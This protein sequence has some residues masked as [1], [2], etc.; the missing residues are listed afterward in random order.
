MLLKKFGSRNVRFAVH[1]LLAAIF[2]SGLC[3]VP[4]LTILADAKSYQSRLNEIRSNKKRVEA[5]IR[6]LRG[7]KGELAFE[8]KTLDKELLVA[9]EELEGVKKSLETEKEE[10]ERLAREL[11][12][13]TEDLEKKRGQLAERSVEIYKQGDLSY[14]DLVFGAEDFSDFIDRVF[15]LQIIYENDQRLITS[16]KD[17]IAEVN[18]KKVEVNQKIIVIEEM[19]EEVELRIEEINVHLEAKKNAMK[20]I[21][22]DEAL[23]NKQV[24]EIEA[25]SKR[26]Q[27]ELRRLAQS[28]S[29]YKG[30]PWT[31]N[32]LKPLNGPIT[33]GF[34][35]RKHPI[36]KV[37]KMHAGVDIDGVTG[38]P[39]KAGG[40][41]KVIYADWRGGYGKCV[42]IDHGKGIVTLYA[43][44]SK[45]LVKKGQIVSAGTKIGKVGSTGYSTGSH[46]HF[47]V[48]VNGK[49]VNPL[50]RL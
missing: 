36:F 29:G 24:K 43:H 48:R 42:M 2:L 45:I 28:G 46:L 41:G 23:Y 44:L 8:L 32:F 26:I 17:Q 34:G 49:P 50:T 21:R 11:E 38:D 37:K 39:I 35:W 1:V 4:G 16:V 5:N 27:A 22:N 7:E 15:F 20:Q 18:L 3:F 13:K 31:G 14:L 19:R 30:K 12:E 25:E 47:E 40:D 10:H 6:R 33:S 9:G